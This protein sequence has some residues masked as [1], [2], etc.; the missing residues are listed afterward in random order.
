MAASDVTHA[1][2]VFE[3][4]SSAPVERVYKVLADAVERARWGTP[5]DTAAF[6]YD[7]TDFRVGGRDSFRCGS[8]DDPQFHGVTAYLDIVP[9]ARIVATETIS[10]GGN[11]LFVGL[12][13]TTLE[14]VGKGTRITLTVQ[15]VSFVGDG[16]VKGTTEGQ[17]AALDNLVA[18]LG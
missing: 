17:N 8:K 1:T 3:R 11:T 13:T 7:S 16:A 4:T 10:T 9:N 18:Y 2:L 5:S 6:I 12:N 15:L 14:P